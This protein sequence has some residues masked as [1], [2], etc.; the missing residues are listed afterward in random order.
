MA[1]R[2]RREPV[3]DMAD[4]LVRAVREMTK[5]PT[6]QACSR[7]HGLIAQYRMA[8]LGEVAGVDVDLGSLEIA[9]LPRK[10]EAA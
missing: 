6:P 9:E 10:R 2:T 1:K 7:V 4:E 5:R 8:W 3:D